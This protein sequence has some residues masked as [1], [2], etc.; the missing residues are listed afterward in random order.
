MATEKFDVRD[1]FTNEVKFTAEIECA[2]DAAP[3]IKLGLAIVW[4]YRNKKDLSCANM[5]GANMADAY[6][7]GANMAG[8]NMA[9]A[10]MAGANMADAYMAGANMAGANMADAYMAGANM[11]DAYMADANMAGANMAGAKWSAGIILKR[12]P[13]QISGLGPWMITLL[14]HHMQ[15]GC[16][17]HSFADWQGFDDR[18]IAAMDGS[19]ALR[20]WKQN[21]DAIL[22]LAAAD[23]R[24]PEAVQ[25]ESTSE[26]KSK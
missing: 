13:V 19:K 11:A 22:A 20:F 21:K 12:A 5:A 8:A 18:R 14:D 24:G 7:A 23:G 10:N 17:L 26:E 15:I 4:G 16:E 9:G 1:R 25:P 6:M 3:S 2:P